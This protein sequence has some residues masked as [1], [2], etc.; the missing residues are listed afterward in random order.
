MA[1][2][3]FSHRATKTIASYKIACHAGS[4]RKKR[5]VHFGIPFRDVIL[6][7]S[8]RGSLIQKAPND[9]MHDGKWA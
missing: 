5:P 4:F 1:K 2:G 7:V 9:L 8:Q 3:L 6:G